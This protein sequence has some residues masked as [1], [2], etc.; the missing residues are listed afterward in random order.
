MAWDDDYYYDGGMVSDSATRKRKKSSKPKLPRFPRKSIFR[1]VPRTDF[2]SAMGGLT[3]GMIFIFPA[4]A[5]LLMGSFKVWLLVVGII[6]AFFGLIVQSGKF[7]LVMM[8]AMVIF[9]LLGFV[10]IGLF[11]AIF[12]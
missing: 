5:A 3:M 10:S 1:K 2:G 8:G 4:L 12:S 6:G 7:A 11:I 9:T